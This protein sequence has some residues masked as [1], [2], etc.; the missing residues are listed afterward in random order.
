[1]KNIARLFNQMFPA[2]P[3][4]VIC[5][6]FALYSFATL[7]DGYGFSFLVLCVLIQIIETSRRRH[8][9]PL[10]NMLRDH[11][12]KKL[13]RARYVKRIRWINIHL[14]RL[15]TEKAELINE[16]NKDQ[17]NDTKSKNA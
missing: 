16:I 2:K 11:R 1:M 17:E 10:E 8:D 13:L 15:N 5:I 6:G 7:A 3:E 12:K 9:D 14:A 4:A